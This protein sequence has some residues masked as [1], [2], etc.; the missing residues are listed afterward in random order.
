MLLV[1]LARLVSATDLVAV[2]FP[3]SL[4]R[5]TKVNVYV[6]NTGVQVSRVNRELTARSPSLGQV[7]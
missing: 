1:G 7:Q 6:N 3:S 4:G 2:E 5:R